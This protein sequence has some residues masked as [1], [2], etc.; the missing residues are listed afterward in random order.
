[1]LKKI[2]KF[3][4]MRNATLVFVALLLGA[5]WLGL[6]YKIAL[7]R[8]VE[9]QGIQKET[10]NLAR[11]FEEHTLRTINN[12]EQTA[13]FLKYQY[14]QEGSSIDIPRDIREGR[15]I[16]QPFVLLSIADEAGDLVASSQVPF[17]SVNV[18]DREHFLAH[19]EVDSKAIF[20]AKPVEGRA[21]KKWTIPMSMRI[22]KPDGSFGGVVIISVDPFYFTKFYNQVDLGKN[23]VVTLVGRDGIVRARQT[24]EKTE[25]GQDLSRSVIMEKATVQGAGFFTAKGQV[26]GISRFMS[27]RTLREYPLVINVGLEETEVLQEFQQR[28]AGYYWIALMGTALILGFMFLLLRI[29]TKQKLAEAQLQQSR[30]TLE[31]QVG[32]RTAEL[33]AA[34]EELQAFNQ[35]L[36]EEIGIRNQAEKALQESETKYWAVLEQSPDAVLLCDPDTGVVVETNSQFNER[37]GYDRAVATNL[38]ELIVDTPERIRQL[39]STVAQTGRS[40]LQR[41]TFF[42]H[43]GRRL[44]MEGSATL[45]T[46]RGRT[47]LLMTLRD[48][49]DEVQREKKILADAKM[50]ARVQTA[51]LP[52]IAPS[53]YL[54]IDTIYRPCGYVGGDLYFMDWRYG[55]SLL[56]GFL[57]DATGH[58]LG[59]A[60][61][62]ASL[63]ALLREVNER[64]LS[65]ADTMRWLNAR[66]GQYFDEG[67]FAGALGFEVDLQTRELR[68]V[69]AGIPKTWVAAKSWQG[70][71][72]CPG[73][74]LGIR[75][76]ETF[77]THTLPI[78]IG[79]A[80]YFM[81]DGL[82]DL[83][84]GRDDLPINQ[85]PTMVK[86][87]QNMSKSAECRDDAT[88]ICIQVRALPRSLVRQDGWPR[89]IRFN[90][91]GDYQRLK[92]DV[93]KIFAE[94]T[95]LPHSLQEVAVNEAVANARECRDGVPRPH[96]AR[97][98][99]NKVGN[100]FI[101]RVKTSRIGFAGNA[102]LRR[103]RSHPEEM[104]SYGE[105]ASMGRGIPMMLSMSDKMTYNSE[106]TEVLLMWRLKDTPM[107]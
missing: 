90:G 55:A 64:D 48:V 70:V 43:N 12:I 57:V 88:A 13:V 62:S 38:F 46:Y 10:A 107:L 20:I 39:M 23:A 56:R 92:G 71:L 63:H 68:L 49:S 74:C 98:R 5:V 75:E 26:D 45:I 89:I 66:T 19:K 2:A 59:T 77:D 103:L 47:L 102:I 21:S 1:M 34:N 80:F 51:L 6:H 87:L 99:F 91:Y 42:H 53:E 86:M 30:D 67:T 32:E 73:M 24:G 101:V 61:H 44:S 76:G 36:E 22:N 69:C 58:G 65:L 82:S 60:L 85:Y 79:D 50:A 15:F 8:R 31:I 33:A 3:W 25:I 93:S 35:N 9:I 81:T 54:G 83:L 106:G 28:I 41:Q 40:P 96:K 78:D 104:F 4:N 105:D 94:V 27:F 84:G 37:L 11:A 7:E 18:K 17:A 16:N 14:E 97:L 100:R 52:K 72:A 95:G 29:D